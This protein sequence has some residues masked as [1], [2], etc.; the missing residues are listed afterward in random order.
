MQ[1]GWTFGVSCSYTAPRPGQGAG[2]TGHHTCVLGAWRVGIA[3]ARSIRGPAAAPNGFI[4]VDGY[5]ARRSVEQSN[6]RGL[7]LPV[8]MKVQSLE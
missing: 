6:G 2:G 5:V 4:C 3:T 8:P 7:Q 1:R